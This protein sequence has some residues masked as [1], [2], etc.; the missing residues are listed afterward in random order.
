MKRAEGWSL[1]A[2]ER[3]TNEL[4]DECVWGVGAFEDYRVWRSQRSGLG[5]VPSLDHHRTTTRM[6]KMTDPGPEICH[7]EP[8]SHPGWACRPSATSG[9]AGSHR[10][11]G[12]LPQ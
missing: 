6:G 1:D 5:P 8:E 12:V 2:L 11:L 9:S 7:Q 4:R 3:W 10:R